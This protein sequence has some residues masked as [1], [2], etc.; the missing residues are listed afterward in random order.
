MSA[1]PLYRQPE[2]LD[3]KRHRSLRIRE[4]TDWSVAATTHA[5]FLT[6]TEFA[7]AAIDYPIVFVE[8]GERDAKGRERVAPMAL[9]GLAPGENLHVQ[10]TRWDARYTPAFMRRYPF[11]SAPVEGLAQPGVFVDVA[12]SGL[13]ETEGE[14]LFG[15]AD[16]PTPALKQAIEFLERFEVEAERT[17]MF[18]DRLL[19]LGILKPMRADAVLLDSRRIAV[20]GFQVVDEEKL[21]GLPDGLV[22][23]LHRK[24][25]LMLMQV[26]LLSLVNLRHLVERKTQ[27]LLAE[28]PLDGTAPTAGAAGTGGATA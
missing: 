19:D 12:W 25:L 9:L 8:I 14:P 22:V 21:Q 7:Q 3:P 13:S 2:L 1:S 11:Y 5:V 18:C 4:L 24:G 15:A 6:A 16:E 10:G 26:H 27:R 23:E 20:E 17:R 28:K